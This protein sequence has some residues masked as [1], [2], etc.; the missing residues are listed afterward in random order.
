[1]STEISNSFDVAAIIIRT[2][3]SVGVP[4]IPRNYQLYYEAYLGSNPA[5]VDGLTRLGTSP[6]QPELDELAAKELGTA[7]VPLIS[8]MNE[9]ISDQVGSLLKFIEKEHQAL[10]GYGNILG[11]AASRLAN[12]SNQT[13]TLLQAMIS[14]LREATGEAISH[15]RGT[16]RHVSKTSAELSDVYEQLERYKQAANT[17]SLTGVNNR[18]AFDEELA[19]V[20]SNSASLPLVSL[21]M[22]DIDHFK[23]VND[24]YGHP[25]GDQ[26][27]RAL[28]HLIK[29]AAPN[30]SFLARTGGEEFTLILKGWTRTEV[31]QFAERLRTAILKR[32]FKNTRA[33]VDLG[34]ITMSIGV[35][36][37]SQAPGAEDLYRAAD[38][39]MY[40][41]KEQGRNQVIFF[42]EMMLGEHK[43]WWIYR[44]G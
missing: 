37:A 36:M 5:L 23:R 13:S 32:T 27:L 41:A 24:T 8:S 4:P 18:R 38:L 7:S 31:A 28:A 44:S 15:G 40:R 16:V 19:N 10:T 39:A 25:V 12:T 22:M 3:R 26:V 34:S 43:D 35:A 2:M 33:G 9:Q 17:D 42:E 14:M 6:T 20:Y 11:E 1:M 29:T 21:M 30:S